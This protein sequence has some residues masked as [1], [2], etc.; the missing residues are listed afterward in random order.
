MSSGLTWDNRTF[1]LDR[2]QFSHAVATLEGI[3]S[4]H[5]FQTAR[6]YYL[7]WALDDEDPISLYT[8]RGG[9]P[10]G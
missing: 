7:P 5:V 1:L 10:L 8:G 4:P 3:S 2:L 6:P 9:L